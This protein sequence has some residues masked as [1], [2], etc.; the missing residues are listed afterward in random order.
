MLRTEPGGGFTGN[1]GRVLRSKE[2]HTPDVIKKKKKRLD[3]C[4]TGREREKRQQR[5]KK[6][7][8]Q[9]RKKKKKKKV[10]TRQKRG[11]PTNKLKGEKVA[12]AAKKNDPCQ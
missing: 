12:K 10:S 11:P 8:R 6:T 4:G 7:K 1:G 5:K 3:K 2:K 9:E